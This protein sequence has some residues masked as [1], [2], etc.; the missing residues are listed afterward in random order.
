MTCCFGNHNT[1]TLHS[2]KDGIWH[3]CGLNPR[4]RFNSYD[5][6][7]FFRAHCDGQHVVSDDE[8]SIFTC[9][10]YLNTE[11]DGGATRFLKDTLML[12]QTLDKP[13]IE[14]AVLASVNPEV[15]SCL[16]FYQPGLLHEGEQ[17]R[18]GHKHILR[19]DVMFKRVEG[20]GREKTP[21]EVEAQQILFQAQHAEG[22]GDFAT[23]QQLYKKA[24]RLDPKL[25]WCS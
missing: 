3:P 2:G 11:F 12:H 16:L 23:A 14:D 1:A 22:Q 9:M 19:S 13:V 6:T 10:F 4:F 8:M 18:G 7:G 25:E 17:L 21:Q 20:S 5:S 24:W 15:G